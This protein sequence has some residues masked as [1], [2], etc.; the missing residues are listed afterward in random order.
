MRVVIGEVADDQPGERGVCRR[1]AEH[2]DEQAEEDGCEWEARRGGHHKAEAIVG[3]VVMDPVNHEVQPAPECMVRL[4]VE[5]QPVEPVFE[6]RPEREAP[7]NE[8]SQLARRVALIGSEPDRS[9]DHRDEHDRRDRRMDAAE[10]VDEPALKQRRRSRQLSGSLLGHRAEI[11]ALRFPAGVPVERLQ[12]AAVPRPGPRRPSPSSIRTSR[13]AGSEIRT[14]RF[15]AVGPGAKFLRF[16][17][18]CSA[19]APRR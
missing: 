7:E 5:D 9:D 2:Q 13:K 15:G 4:P 18:S 1:R 14:P 19:P 10:E 3:M 12:I 8:Q 16:A 6:Q 11:L 17:E